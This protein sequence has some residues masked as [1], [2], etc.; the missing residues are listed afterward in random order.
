MAWSFAFIE[1]IRIGGALPFIAL[2][3][4]R[5]MIIRRFQQISRAPNGL[6][7]L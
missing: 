5:R 6:K 4:I 1:N 3:I 2:N 7:R